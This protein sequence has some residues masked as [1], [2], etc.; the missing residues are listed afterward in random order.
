MMKKILKIIPECDQYDRDSSCYTLE[1][2]T[3]VKDY[4]ERE[5]GDC[6]DR[7]YQAGD[8]KDN[9]SNVSDVA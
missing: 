7:L 6:S 9:Y 3:F 4:L 8:K 1:R 2:G 5:N